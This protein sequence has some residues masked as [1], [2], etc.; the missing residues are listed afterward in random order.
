[1]K[2]IK[3]SIRFTSQTTV[4]EFIDWWL[5][6]EVRHRLRSGSLDEA[7][8][9][10]A[11]L[12]DL[13]HEPL[14]DVTLEDLISWRSGLLDEL[15][16]ST[17]ANTRVTVRQMFRRAVQLGVIPFSPAAELLPPKLDTKPGRALAALEVP[18]LLEATADLRYGA[19]VHI[20]FTQGPRVSEALGLSWDDIDVAAATATVRRAVTY[21]KTHGTHLGPPKTDGAEGIHH[22]SP[23]AMEAIAEWRIVDR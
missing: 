20:L 14:A 2:P 21:D 16:A 1:M 11:R 9:R 22:L 10:L 8:T 6:T 13:R 5:M 17:V 3:A 7:R 4:A 12:K 19:V 23:G 15:A 18:R